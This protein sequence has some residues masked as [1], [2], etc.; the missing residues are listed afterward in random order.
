MSCGARPGDECVR[1]HFARFL[2]GRR[3]SCSTV[4]REHMG[5]SSL[6]VKRLQRCWPSQDTSYCRLGAHV[7]AKQGYDRLRA[8]R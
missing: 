7:V 2:N 6:Q 3:I 1:G 4:K 5:R 8:R